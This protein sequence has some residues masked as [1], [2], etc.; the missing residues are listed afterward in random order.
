[1]HLYSFHQGHIYILN[2]IFGIVQ[3]WGRGAPSLYVSCKEAWLQAHSR[4]IHTMGGT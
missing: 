4:G 1:M 2:L 3:V